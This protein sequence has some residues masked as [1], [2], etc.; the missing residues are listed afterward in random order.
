MYKTARETCLKEFQARRSVTRIPVTSRMRELRQIS[1]EI[2]EDVEFVT[3]LYKKLPFAQWFAVLNWT[4]LALL[5]EY[6]ALNTKISDSE[7]RFIIAKHAIDCLRF[8]A[9]EAASQNPIDTHHL[10][11]IYLSII[12]FEFQAVFKHRYVHEQ[13]RK[14]LSAPIKRIPSRPRLLDLVNHTQNGPVS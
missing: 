11:Q 12:L 14:R 10:K 9:T 4:D 2:A 13:Q 1:T 7:Q 5:N 3:S 6:L 8:K